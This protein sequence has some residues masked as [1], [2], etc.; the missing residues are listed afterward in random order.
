MF[1]RHD[2]IFELGNRKG[3][4]FCRHG[5]NRTYKAAGTERPEFCIERFLLRKH[6]SFAK[7]LY[8][9]FGVSRWL[10]D[11]AING[12]GKPRIPPHCCPLLV[13][14]RM[15]LLVYRQSNGHKRI[16]NGAIAVLLLLGAS[17]LDFVLDPL[18]VCA[19]SGCRL[20]FSATA[21]NEYDKKSTVD[22]SKS[23]PLLA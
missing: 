12:V 9:L 11:F 4:Q 5:S 16:K 21:E 22:T 14:H 2:L 13:K 8:L 7:F 6:Q 10:I 23:T 3:S 19:K 15:R 20:R 17:V 1:Q 18:D